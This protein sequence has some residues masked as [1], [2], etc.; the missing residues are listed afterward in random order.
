[1]VIGQRSNCGTCHADADCGCNLIKGNYRCVCR[2]GYYGAGGKKSG[3]KRKK[4]N[5]Y[6]FLLLNF[7]LG[8]LSNFREILFLKAKFKLG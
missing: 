2:R 4:I 3:C 6:K 8:F 5:Q 7:F 1:M